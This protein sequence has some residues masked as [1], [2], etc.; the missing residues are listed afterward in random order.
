VAEQGRAG[1]ASSQEVVECAGLGRSVGV[2]RHR[3]KVIISRRSWSERPPA[4]KTILPP[5]GNRS[6]T[7]FASCVRAK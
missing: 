3:A 7:I 6:K 4:A 1:R 2:N 5:E